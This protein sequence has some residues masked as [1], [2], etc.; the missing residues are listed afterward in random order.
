MQF[1]EVNND[2]VETKLQVE[3]FNV[4]GG[5]LSSVLDKLLPKN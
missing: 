4:R 3:S 5:G 2:R 1:L